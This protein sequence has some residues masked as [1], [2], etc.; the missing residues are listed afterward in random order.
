MLI[1]FYTFLDGHTMI[2]RV[3]IEFYL[4]KAKIYGEKMRSN[5]LIPFALNGLMRTNLPWEKQK[6]FCEPVKWL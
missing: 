5:L 4:P 2:F 1:L 6:S 3:V